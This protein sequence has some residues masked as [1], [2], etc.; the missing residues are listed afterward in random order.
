MMTVEGPDELA[1]M[2]QETPKHKE[3][4]DAR[5]SI[6]LSVLRD[7]P[8]LGFAIADRPEAPDEV[9]ACLALIG[10][11]RSRSRLVMRNSLPPEVVELLETDPEVG[12][13][14]HGVHAPDI[15]RTKLERF[16]SHRWPS[17]RALAEARL[18]SSEELESGG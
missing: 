6:W 3:V 17:V 18:A 2:L 1:Q 10:D 12:A 14:S 16:L 4:I 5:L 9:L 11:R 13:A 15:E 7:R 8:E